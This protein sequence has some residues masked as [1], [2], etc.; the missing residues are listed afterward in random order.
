MSKKIVVHSEETKK[1]RRKIENKLRKELTEKQ[2]IGLANLLE[3]D[4][5]TPQDD[6]KE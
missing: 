1:V 5:T 6:D 2:I 3:I 4:E